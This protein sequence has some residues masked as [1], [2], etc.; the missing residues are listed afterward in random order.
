MLS[1]AKKIFW[2]QIILKIDKIIN[3]I[4]GR[5]ICMCL[6]EIVVRADIYI[7]NYYLI[8]NNS[9]IKSINYFL[10]FWTKCQEFQYKSIPGR[11]PMKTR[12]YVKKLLPAKKIKIYRILKTAYV[13]D[14]KHVTSISNLWFFNLLYYHEVRYQIS[15][16]R[17]PSF[18]N[19]DIQRRYT[20]N[21]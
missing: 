17:N 16:K 7:C 21:A 20:E 15:N 2:F 10:L 18:I 8:K 3:K 1:I 13:F 9:I 14:N 19:L 4:N 5:N 6:N 11:N 12:K